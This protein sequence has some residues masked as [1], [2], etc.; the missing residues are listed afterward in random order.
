VYTARFDAPAS[1]SELFAVNVDTVESDLTKLTAEQLREGVWSGIPFDTSRENLDEAPVLRIGRRG[2]LSK[3]LL[4][5]VLGLAF[6][7]TFL[8]WRFGHHPT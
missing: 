1:P 7:E 6:L 4:Y 5:A 8:A 2:T 3:E